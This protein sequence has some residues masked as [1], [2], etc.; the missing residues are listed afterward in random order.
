MNS[1]LYIKY[2]KKKEKSIKKKGEEERQ[3]QE[4]RKREVKYIGKSLS[5]GWRW[6]KFEREIFL[7][8]KIRISSSSRG[9][10]GASFLA[11]PWLDISR[12]CAQGTASPNLAVEGGGLPYTI[13]SMYLNA[14]PLGNARTHA[15]G[16]QRIDSVLSLSLV[17][18]PTERTL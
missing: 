11:F 15:C 18:P 17:Q 1:W 3:R 14:P 8:S 4:E 12:G 5:R 7:L 16:A 10:R 6:V 13:S 2:K 9:W